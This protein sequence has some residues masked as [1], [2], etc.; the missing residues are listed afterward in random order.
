M[1]TFTTY[2]F[3]I[4]FKITFSIQRRWSTNLSKY[5]CNLRR[6]FTRIIRVP[7][8]QIKYDSAICEFVLIYNRWKTFLLIN[9]VEKIQKWNHHACQ[10]K[11]YPYIRVY[12]FCRFTVLI[13]AFC[14]KKASHGFDSTL[15]KTVAPIHNRRTLFC[16]TLFEKLARLSNFEW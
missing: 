16:Q 7:T 1:T 10:M 12:A 3:L 11:A 14:W 2:S 4:D 13:Y 9:L 5:F 15:L 8:I 6:K